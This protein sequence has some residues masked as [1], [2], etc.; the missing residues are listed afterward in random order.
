MNE[1]PA[2]EETGPQTIGPYTVYTITTTDVVFLLI[3]ALRWVK[4]PQGHLESGALRR[5]VR[6]VMTLLRKEDLP[7]LKFECPPDAEWDVVRDE[8]QRRLDA[9]TER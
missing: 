5:K 4:T 6:Q 7:A 3:M 9:P 1:T 2:H 8:I